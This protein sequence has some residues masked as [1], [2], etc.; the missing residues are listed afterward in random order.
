MAIPET[1]GSLPTWGGTNLP[2]A[3]TGILSSVSG[4]GKILIVSDRG[5]DDPETLLSGLE[6]AECYPAELPSMISWL[7]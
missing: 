1:G 5:Y 4:V 3:I 7:K 6:Y 2:V